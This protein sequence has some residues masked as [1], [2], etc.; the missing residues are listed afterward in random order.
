MNEINITRFSNT[1]A[2][3]RT[4][5]RTFVDLHW[6][7]YRDDPQYIPLLDYEYLGFRLLGIDGYFEPRSPFLQ[8]A[9]VAFFLA[10]DAQRRLVGR[11]IAFINDD[12]NAHWKEKTGFFGFF[13]SIDDESLLET[14]DL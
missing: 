6:T 1:D 4:K 3:A 2:D 13:E 10:H 8:H 14:R 9:T 11:C 7:H 12:Y 5:L